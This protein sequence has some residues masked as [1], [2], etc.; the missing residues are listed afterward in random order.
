VKAQVLSVIRPMTAAIEAGHTALG[1]GNVL[2]I[3]A[4]ISALQ[5]FRE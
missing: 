1:S 2:T 3:A 5:E 4:A